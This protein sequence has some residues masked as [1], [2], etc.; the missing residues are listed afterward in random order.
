MSEW[1]VELSVDE[2]GSIT[3]SGL[4]ARRRKITMK[5]GFGII[6]AVLL[7]VLFSP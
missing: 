7:A 1:G 3:R 4:D 6:T 5:K 2:E